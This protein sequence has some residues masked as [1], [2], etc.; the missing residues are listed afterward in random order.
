MKLNKKLSI[1]FGGYGIRPED[2]KPTE[3]VLP[4][5]TIFLTGGYHDIG[6]GKYD[7]A[8]HV[9]AISK[10][11]DEELLH[12]GKSTFHAEVMTTYCGMTANNDI[13]RI[14]GY[15]FIALHDCISDDFVFT[16]ADEVNELL[17]LKNHPVY[18]VLFNDDYK[19]CNITRIDRIDSLY[20]VKNVMVQLHSAIGS[21]YYPMIHPA[22]SDYL[23]KLIHPFYKYE[24]VVLDGENGDM[25]FDEVLNTA[26]SHIYPQ[27]KERLRGLNLDF[28]HDILEARY[29]DFL[30][31]IM[32]EISKYN[33]VPEEDFQK[34][35]IFRDF[36][37]S[38]PLKKAIDKMLNIETE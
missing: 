26:L 8:L 30:G 15:G 9:L 36:A 4:E 38:I 34:K 13:F 14:N 27:Y 3:M 11:S 7:N 19:L 24:I 32:G 2:N 23:D 20:K 37:S 10:A 31:Y 18:T 25:L 1:R 28:V 21:R 17:D 22:G 5:D 35:T 12:V 33:D 6:P 16:D 29:D